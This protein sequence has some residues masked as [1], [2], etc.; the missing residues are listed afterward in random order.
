LPSAITLPRTPHRRRDARDCVSYPSI[1]STFSYCTLCPAS[2]VRADS[3]DAPVSRL[4]PC[5]DPTASRFITPRYS[6]VLHVV[7]QPMHRGSRPTANSKHHCAPGSI[8][9]FANMSRPPNIPSHPGP[10]HSY[11]PHPVPHAGP[12]RPETNTQSQHVHPRDQNHAQQLPSLR[13]LLEPELLDKRPTDP[14]SRTS[15]AQYA[16]GSPARYESSSPTLKRRHDFDGY[17]HGHP[18]HNAIVS[19]TSYHDRQPLSSATTDS[20]SGTSSTP[21]SAFS[22][23]HIVLQRHHSFAH[24]SHHDQADNFFR[25]S[26]TAS[27]TATT[28]ATPMAQENIGDA[29]RPVR[30]RIDGSSRAPVRSS[31]CVGQREIQG[32]GLC[33]IYEDGTY[34]RAII[35][36]ETVNP[37]WGITKAGKPRKRLAQACLTCREKKIKCEPGYPKC[38]QCAKS[39]RLC[40]G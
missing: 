21:G 7:G 37:D 30:R 22:A 6:L 20:Q 39:Q 40:R 26:S 9:M 18:E 29:D 11:N 33:Y 27:D 15:A 24:P 35:D 34:C 1:F 28:I 14:P 12:S 16:H 3:V 38:L 17:A 5:V 2:R 19:Q 13:T 10:P 31:R 32:E 4:E 25:P 8:D 36:G 23:S